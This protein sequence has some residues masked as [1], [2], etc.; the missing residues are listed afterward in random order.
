MRDSCDFEFV[1]FHDSPAS[2]RSRCPPVSG[3]GQPVSSFVFRDYFVVAGGVVAGV[4]AP[5][6]AA[7]GVVAGVVAPRPA[8]GAAGVVPPR[9][10][11]GAADVGVDPRAGAA[12]APLEFRRVLISSVI[13]HSLAE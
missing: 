11:A 2:S 7:G 4:V 13:L 6:P 10:A 5:R 8:A 1:R 3:G 9:P 12:V